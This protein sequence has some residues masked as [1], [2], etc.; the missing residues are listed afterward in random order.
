MEGRAVQSRAKY[1]LPLHRELGATLG[2]MQ[3]GR[4]EYQVPS[5][6]ST[7]VVPSSSSFSFFS[8]LFLFLSVGVFCLSVS[9]F[10]CDWCPGRPKE[11]IGSWGT[12]VQMAMSSHVGI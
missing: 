2:Y 3:R 7:L 1:H 11:D 10:I 4:S 5:S 12:G 6:V 8:N 9:L